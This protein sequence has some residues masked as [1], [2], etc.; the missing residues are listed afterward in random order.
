MLD[1]LW[2]VYISVKN[3]QLR[4]WPNELI[5][6]FFHLWCLD[7]NRLSYFSS[8]PEQNIG[9]IK[10]QAVKIWYMCIFLLFFS[11][12]HP[13]EDSY[14]FKVTTIKSF[15]FTVPFSSLKVTLWHELSHIRLL[16]FQWSVL[17]IW[18]FLS[19]SPEL[20]EWNSKRGLL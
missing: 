16:P 3:F 20:P 19:S 18:F 10:T 12:I 4:S 8:W 17:C 9:C 14:L 2:S 15:L 13:L 5:F 7:I 1:Y 11:L 6:Y